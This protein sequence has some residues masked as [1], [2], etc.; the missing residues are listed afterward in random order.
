MRKESDFAMGD[1]SKD[2][3][4]YCMRVDGSMQSYEEKLIGTIDFIV[5]SQGLERRA[6]ETAAKDI[7]K[8]LPA[9]KENNALSPIKN[10]EDTNSEL[11]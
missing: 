11:R 2:Y 9:W 5:Q 4:T 7:L 8:R 10:E 6:A 1:T 3:C